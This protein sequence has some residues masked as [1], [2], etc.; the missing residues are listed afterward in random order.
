MT[1]L[2]SEDNTFITVW[3]FVCI[4]VN[5]TTQNVVGEFGSTSVDRWELL[6][7]ALTTIEEE[8]F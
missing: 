6:N 7:L 3:V 8:G 1:I 4:S 5:K 2:D